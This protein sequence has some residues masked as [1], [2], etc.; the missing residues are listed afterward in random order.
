MMNVVFVGMQILILILRRNFE[1]VQLFQ[2]VIVFFFGM[3]IDLN[4]MLTEWMAS[5]NLPINTIVQIA[6]CTILGFGIALEVKCGSVTK[7]GE[8][9]TIAI[10]KVTG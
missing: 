8:G 3:L 5:E 9:I 4:M 6:G 7:P 1:W 10:N 2:L